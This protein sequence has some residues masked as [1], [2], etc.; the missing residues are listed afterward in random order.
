MSQ[1][2]SSI[3]NYWSVF[4]LQICP[5]IVTRFV[6]RYFVTIAMCHYW[7]EYDIPKM[8]HLLLPKKSFILGWTV[9][10]SFSTW[11]LILSKAFKSDSLSSFSKKN[12]LKLMQ[13][14][15]DQFKG[16]RENTP[17]LYQSQ[18]HPRSRLIQ[19]S[20]MG[21]RGSTTTTITANPSSIS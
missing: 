12:L 3:Y 2:M 14:S 9:N 4:E 18:M 17:M 11:L 6:P 8:S 21:K 10:I 13:L 19:H 5:P 16:G 15:V 7:S 1:S 20:G